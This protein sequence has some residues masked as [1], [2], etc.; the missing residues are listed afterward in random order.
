MCILLGPSITFYGIVFLRQWRIVRLTPTLSCIA[1]AS[2]GRDRK[3]LYAAF[4]GASRLLECIDEDAKRIM[5]TPSLIELRDPS[6]PYISELTNPSAPE[7][8]CKFEILG[9]CHPARDDRLLYIAET[10][11]GRN[12]VLKFTRRYSIE[13]HLFCAERGRGPNI[14]GFKRLPG[15]WCVVAMEHLSK[16]V[17]P[18]ESPHLGT[19]YKTWIRDLEELVQSFHNVDLVH[20]DLREPN[21]ICNGETVMLIDFDWGGRVGDAR[22]P[23]GRLSAELTDGRTS[24]NPSISKDDDRRVL[25]NT[26]KSIEAE[27]WVI[28]KLPT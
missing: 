25:R 4:F 24:T 1:S 3:A 20:G 23:S 27:A 19:L 16:S 12:I 2:E 22:Y 13:L 28:S 5:R 10:S 14:L 21:I 6:F 17:H 26:L 9:L 18:S 15:D 8:V 7:E 11:N